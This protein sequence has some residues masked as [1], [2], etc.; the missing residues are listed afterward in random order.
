MGRVN[1]KK[2]ICE[3]Y[4][5][6]LIDTDFHMGVYNFEKNGQ[7]KLRISKIKKCNTNTYTLRDWK[8]DYIKESTNFCDIKEYL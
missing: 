5:F 2:S 4:G 3:T 6:E 1:I 7:Y 8:G